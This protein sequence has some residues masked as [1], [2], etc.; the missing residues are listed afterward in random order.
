MTS[1]PLAYAPQCVGGGGCQDQLTG[2][3]NP[4]DTLLYAFIATGEWGKWAPGLAYFGTSAWTYSAKEVANP[5]DG[6]PLQSAQSRPTSVRQTSYF[7][8]WLDYQVNSWFTPE[9]GYWMSRSV[10]NESGQRGNQF[11]DRYQDMRVYIGF[12]V[13]LDNLMKSLQGGPTDAGIVRANN[14]RTPFGAF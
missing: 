5:V 3:L 14:Q 10:L 8:A 13:G 4:S 6:T 7:S 2:V 9:V 1:S 12:N 11:F